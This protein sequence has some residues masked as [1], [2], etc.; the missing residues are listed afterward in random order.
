MDYPFIKRDTDNDLVIRFKTEANIK[1]ASVS[2][3]YTASS[4]T[5]TKHYNYFNSLLKIIE[6]IDIIM[7]DSRNDIIEGI[8]IISKFIN[9]PVLSPLTLNDDE[10]KLDGT[11]HIFTIF[12]NKRY[13]S[14]LKYIDANTNIITYINSKAY[15]PDIKVTY[16]HDTKEE[17]GIAQDY[18]FL[19]SP[20]LHI[21]KGGVV[22]GQIIEYKDIN[23]KLDESY[24]HLTNVIQIPVSV[25]YGNYDRH[26]VYTVDAREPKLKELLSLY[27]V[28][29]GFNPSIKGYYDIR[30]Y[31]KLNK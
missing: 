1:L 5:Y 30:K 8:S 23:I 25:I 6:S 20:K 27:N 7:F 15:L 28:N 26:T 14:I 19:S 24:E 31:K 10:F 9:S 22:T 3:I 17:L 4:S 18:N 12:E 21:T 29:I 13:D 16:N 2:N 11:N